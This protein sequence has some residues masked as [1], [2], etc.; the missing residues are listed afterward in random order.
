[1][2]EEL[3]AEGLPVN[4]YC[5]IQ[6]PI[7]QNIFA[8]NA[9]NFPCGDIFSYSDISDNGSKHLFSNEEIQNLLTDCYQGE[10]QFKGNC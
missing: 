10:A 3:C 1:M 2:K 7:D 6:I 4:S 9:D 8:V 5:P